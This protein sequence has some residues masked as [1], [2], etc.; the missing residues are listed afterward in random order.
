VRGLN[1]EGRGGELQRLVLRPARF[2]LGDVALSGHQAQ[3]SL[4]ALSGRLRIL[5]RVVD[6]R[7]LRQ[8]GQ[9][10]ALGQVK[11]LDGLPEVRLGGALQPIG[12]VAVVGLVEVEQQDVVAAVAGRQA[13]GQDRLP[14]LAEERALGPL[15][16]V[17]QQ[18]TGDLLGDRAAAGDHLPAGQVDPQRAQDAGEVDADVAVEVGVLGSDGRVDA[19]LGDAIQSHGAV[20]PAFRVDDLVEQAAL[21]IQ[22]ARR[23]QGQARFQH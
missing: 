7:G 14:Q 19:V 9:Q 20:A 15:L 11:R 2:L 1:G 23:G 8:P 13:D 6:G 4:L 22:D 18:V 21:A 12:Q 16:R 3:D 17:E 10:R 5:Q